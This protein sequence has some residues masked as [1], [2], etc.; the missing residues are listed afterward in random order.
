MSFV[1]ATSAGHVPPEYAFGAGGV[2]A[3]AGGVA[4]QL[5]AAMTAAPYG[6]C[7]VHIGP[8]SMPPSGGPPPAPA[9]PPPPLLL[10]L[11]LDGAA[12]DATAWDPPVED[13]APPAPFCAEPLPP[14][15]LA[16][17]TTRQHQAKHARIMVRPW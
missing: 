4:E 9:A 2:G 11:L 5:A 1:P 14:H 12:V 13:Q 16:R 17:R 10:L 15:E 8:A 7:T 6:F 3:P